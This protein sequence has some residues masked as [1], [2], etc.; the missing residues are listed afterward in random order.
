MQTIGFEV[1]GF[2]YSVTSKK[3]EDL[4]EDPVYMA[5]CHAAMN[6][7]RIVMRFTDIMPN[8][9]EHV[10]WRGLSLYDLQSAEIDMNNGYAS[11]HSI[12]DLFYGLLEIYNI[13]YYE[14]KF[15]ILDV[16]GLVEKSTKKILGYL[17]VDQLMDGLDMLS[18]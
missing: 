8:A 6:D 7:Y 16:I 9:S 15:Q 10:D 2:M 17:E 18:L 5:L 12:T 11:F 13:L 14:Q 1:F 3:R 4:M